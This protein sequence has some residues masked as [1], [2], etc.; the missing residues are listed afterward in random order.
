MR[1]ARVPRMKSLYLPMNENQHVGKVGNALARTETRMRV[2]TSG[3][4][5]A[6]PWPYIRS[7]KAPQFVRLRFRL[8][9]RGSYEFPPT[10]GVMEYY[11]SKTAETLPH[12]SAVPKVIYLFVKRNR[13]ATVDGSYEACLRILHT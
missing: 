4:F 2:K 10:S 13:T 7:C 12:K 3:Q 11:R 6:E 1:P 5:A 8:S 9:C